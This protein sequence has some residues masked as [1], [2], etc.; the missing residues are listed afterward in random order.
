MF[1][2]TLKLINQLR[3]ENSLP[4]YHKSPS[5]LTAAAFELEKLNQYRDLVLFIANDYNELS[6]DKIKTQRDE[7]RKL[8]QNLI[9]KLED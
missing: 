2:D 4:S 5:L 7:W 8:C 1:F 3:A 9:N 6:Y